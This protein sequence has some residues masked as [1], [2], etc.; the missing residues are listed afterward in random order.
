MAHPRFHCRVFLNRFAMMVVA[1]LSYTSWSSFYAVCTRTANLQN[2]V[3]AA[4]FTAIMLALLA[5]LAGWYV[6][7]ETT[8]HAQA[9]LAM[10]EPL[11]QLKREEAAA[12]LT[13]AVLDKS[14]G[15]LSDAMGYTIV[16]VWAGLVWLRLHWLAALALGAAAGFAVLLGISVAQERLPPSG[17][18]ST[19]GLLHAWLDL[20]STVWIG[21]FAWFISVPAHKALQDAFHIDDGQAG[22]PWMWILA[23]MGSAA[24]VVVSGVCV[25]MYCNSEHVEGSDSEVNANKPL[26][27]LV[28]EKV[29]P[30][31]N[32]AA[33]YTS[34]RLAKTWVM[35]E[36]ASQDSYF[37][38]VAWTTLTVFVVCFL[39][40]LIKSVAAPDTASSVALK[41]KLETQVISLTART[42]TWI[43]AAMV[44]A[45]YQSR[46]GYEGWEW[47]VVG[48]VTQ[49]Q[50]L[51]VEHLRVQWLHGHGFCAGAG[52]EG[53]ESAEEEELG[54][55][56]DCNGGASSRSSS[57]S[58]SSGSGGGR[59]R[60]VRA[61][62]GA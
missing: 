31:F 4:V 55:L 15:N 41:L 22:E 57:S 8:L 21:S 17:S 61:R 51:L 1:G 23:L 5:L 34:A 24:W 56:L 16:E 40:Q 46:R 32:H 47:M 45:L 14:F 58:G 13:A 10:D 33:F 60:M 20:L 38:V 29:E 12:L 7:H 19:G 18:E 53:P 3:E 37:P 44:C 62:E 11:L 36:W 52:D 49:G 35:T 6:R 59:P 43:D 25:S 50:A 48:L 28:C 2:P 27:V 30:M 39:E 42:F 54:L 26:R 9:K